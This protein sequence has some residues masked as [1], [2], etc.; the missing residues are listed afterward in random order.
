MVSFCSALSRLGVAMHQTLPLP[1]LRAADSQKDQ[2]E[3][4][5]AGRRQENYRKV[6]EASEH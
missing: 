6:Q 2:R 5:L 1:K 4:H 3:I